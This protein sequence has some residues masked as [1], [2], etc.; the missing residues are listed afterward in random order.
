MRGVVSVSTDDEIVRVFEGLVRTASEA[1]RLLAEEGVV[2]DSGA[3]HPAV[4]IEQRCSAEIAR[5]TTA[6]SDLFGEQKK[7]HGSSGRG[8]FQSLRAVE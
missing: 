4:A 2:T 7:V 1:Q 5:W 3:P 6:R 8:K